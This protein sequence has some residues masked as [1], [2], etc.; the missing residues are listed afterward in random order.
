[1]GE[2]KWLLTQNA[3]LRPFGIYNWTLPALGANLDD[4]RSVLVCPQAGACAAFCYA[5]NG[6]YL[7]PKVKAAHA[8]NLKLVLDDLD[9]FKGDMIHE[10]AYRVKPGGWI[11]IHDSGDFFSDE[12]LEAWMDIARI[13]PGVTFYCYTKEVE[14]FK[15]IVERQYWSI[16]AGKY[17]PIKP[18]NFM[19]L[20]S[21][22]GKQDHLIDR[23][24]DRHAEVFPT[25]EAL[26]AAGYMSQEGDDR[27]AVTLPTTRIGIVANNIKH[28]NK[29]LAGK[30]FG[31]AEL[32][33]EAK[34]ALRQAKVEPAPVMA[35]ALDE[36]VDGQLSLSSHSVE[37][38]DGC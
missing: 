30:T 14:R 23:D 25:M 2:R 21:L 38:W 8:R 12:Y 19:Y 37:P 3:E 11:R 6:T 31:E 29:R 18:D 5:R 24:K 32:A 4:G 9:K 20:F 15:R 1:M 22:G 16:S 33:R 34:L 26:L 10:A 28:F 17:M 35:V 36:V 7:F 27:Q 13:V